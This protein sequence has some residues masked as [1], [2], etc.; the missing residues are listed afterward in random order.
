MDNLNA[1]IGP[2]YVIYPDNADYL[3]DLVEK[4]IGLILNRIFFRRNGSVK[5]A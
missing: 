2:I 1:Q 5:Q 4:E 3:M